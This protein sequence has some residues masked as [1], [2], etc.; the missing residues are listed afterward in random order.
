MYVKRLSSLKIYTLTTVTYD[1][2]RKLGVY[3]TNI[4]F[5]NSRTELDSHT[6]TCT[7]G[8]NEPITHTHEINGIPKKV[9]DHAFDSTLGSVKNIVVVND[10]LAYDCLRTR[11]VIILKVNQAI[12][13]P[14]M[15]HNLLCV[16]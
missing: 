6:D 16:M 10:T 4:I 7:V 14:T 9:N 1:T 5:H 8:Y 12:H 13:L 15:K 11:I 2:P 3:S